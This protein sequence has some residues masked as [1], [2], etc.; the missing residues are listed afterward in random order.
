MKA[1]HDSITLRFKNEELV[2]LREKAAQSNVRVDRL[3]VDIIR[4]HLRQEARIP[5]Y[6]EALV[7]DALMQPPVIAPP[8]TK[9]VTGLSK[10]FEFWLGNNCHNPEVLRLYKLLEVFW[11]SENMPV[12]QAIPGKTRLSEGATP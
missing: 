3:C 8:D 9:P 7:S 5:D 4:L 1:A 11:K 6:T 12:A 2:T 10:E